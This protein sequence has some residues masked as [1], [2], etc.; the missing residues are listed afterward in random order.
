MQILKKLYK[1]EI[2][3]EL[4]YFFLSACVLLFSLLRIPSLIEP[5]WYGDEGIYQV[6]GR[7]LYQGHLLYRDIWDNKPPLL[8][9]YYMLVDG[10]LFYI[11]LLSFIFG[12]AAVI[13]FFIVARKIF[14]NKST[15]KFASTIIFVLFFGSP[16]LE[17]NIANAE[18]FMLFPILLSLYLILK[19]TKKSPRIL[20]ISAGLLLSIAALTKIVAI[21]DLGAFMIIL[22]TL[23][24][25]NMKFADIKKHIFVNP[26]ELII[27][28]RQESML[29]LSFIIPFLVT[30]MFFLFT[31][32]FT[33]FIRAAFFQNVGYVGYG[34]YLNVNFPYIHFQL[35]QGLLI[36]KSLLLIFGVSLI[37]YYRK[38]F[39]PAGIVI[40]IWLIFSLFNSFFSARPYTHYVLVLL[41]VFCLLLGLAL[42]GRKKL[43]AHI[44]IVVLIV[45]V[46]K[47]NFWYHKK[48]ISYYKNYISY[49]NGEINTN[50][51]QSFF[52]KN[53]PRDYDIANFIKINTEENE[54]IFLL[55]DSGQIYYM[56]DKLPPGRY[57]VSYHMTTYKDGISETKKALL[58]KNP[59]YII[60]TKRDA[61]L[62]EL[63]YGYKPLYKIKS[64][65]IYEREY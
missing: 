17:G 28:F 21:F 65:E 46:V 34:N 23:R 3:P 35:N 58:Q 37:F 54:N 49:M 42:T 16:I 13:T 36:I 8:Y 25:Y 30:L 38:L 7:A 14:Q 22:F 47:G 51:Y 39:S 5:H 27:I 12:V 56:A 11:R 26:K 48:N 6:I 20:P 50:T 62:S 63:L 24:F 60:D 57:I 61:R 32:A 53:V 15:P 2:K 45:F 41:P 29:I 18:N 52:D 33:D 44:L 40:Y 64:A 1:Y 10:D 4:D 19:L 9:L 55:S 43:I 59:K 31:G